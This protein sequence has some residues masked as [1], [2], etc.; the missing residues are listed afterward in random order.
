VIVGGVAIV[1]LVS[2]IVAVVVVLRRRNIPAP[3]AVQV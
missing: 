3:Q 2:L 1:A